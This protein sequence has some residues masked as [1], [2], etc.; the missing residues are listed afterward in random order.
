[1]NF[2]RSNFIKT[3]RSK[4]RNNFPIAYM[5]H[6]DTFLRSHSKFSI[7][8]SHRW[9]YRFGPSENDEDTGLISFYGVNEIQHAGIIVVRDDPFGITSDHKVIGYFESSSHFM[10]WKTKLQHPETFY[11]L[12]GAITGMQKPYFKLRIPLASPLHHKNNISPR[13][14]LIF[15]I[16]V[17][18]MIAKDWNLPITEKMITCF[19]TESPDNSEMK[20]DI[21]IQDVCFRSSQDMATFGNA[22]RYRVSTHE[23]LPIL[24]SYLKNDWTS[25][26]CIEVVGERK[27]FY[28]F[29]GNRYRSRCSELESLVSNVSG[30]RVLNI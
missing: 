24:A 18:L 4:S 2:S 26:R 11:E 17:I 14:I 10:K 7:R 13:S 16:N 15:Y 3:L 8:D 25:N 20:F 21:V 22:I 29:G 12:V 9:F 19:R 5:R 6:Q 23:T 28:N 27:T 1:M 30:C